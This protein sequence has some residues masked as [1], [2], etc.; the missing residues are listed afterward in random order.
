MKVVA[1]DAGGATLKA[2]VVAPGVTPTASILP[3]HVASTS[4]NPSAV[5]M[6]QK[7]QELEHQRA[8]LRY[9][10]PVQR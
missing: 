6:G 4:A 3:N 8:K 7:L 10:R 1:L 2:S 5:F 9:L